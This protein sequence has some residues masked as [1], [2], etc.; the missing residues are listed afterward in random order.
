MWIAYSSSST[1]LFGLDIMTECG[2]HLQVYISSNAID[3]AVLY[4]F[5][6]SLVKNSRRTTSILPNFKFTYGRDNIT[7]TL[8][9]YPQ[10]PQTL[11]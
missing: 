6:K 5:F 8:L 3:P 7:S 10:V 4:R 2:H 11:W 1:C 9:K